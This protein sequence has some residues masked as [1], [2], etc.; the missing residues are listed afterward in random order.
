M[1]FLCLGVWQPERLES[2]LKEYRA[3]GETECWRTDPDHG[4]QSWTT[5]TQEQALNEQTRRTL[6]MA[7]IGHGPTGW[8]PPS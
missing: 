6:W 5:P 8:V 2:I 7:P 3:A 1:M 4:C